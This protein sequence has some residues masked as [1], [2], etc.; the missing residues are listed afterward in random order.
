MSLNMAYFTDNPIPPK[1]VIPPEHAFEFE[2]ESIKIRNKPKKFFMPID[3]FKFF[4]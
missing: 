4:V 2:K 3:I 1:N